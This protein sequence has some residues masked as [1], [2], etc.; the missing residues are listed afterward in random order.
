MTPSERLISMLGGDT[1]EPV[2]SPDEIDDCLA[3]GAIP[4][5]AG[6]FTPDPHWTPTYDYKRSAAEGW[7][8]KAAKV[9]ADYT[10]TIEGR[11]LNRQQM[12][13]NFLKMAAEADAGSSPRFF[14]LTSD[15]E[16]W[17]V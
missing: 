5:S 10:I 2:L 14:G 11:E 17:R 7:R 6:L 12:I 3:M 8:R 13:D 16:S 9:A 15:V 4:D 1:A